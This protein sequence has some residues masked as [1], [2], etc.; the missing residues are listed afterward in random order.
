MCENNLIEI[1]ILYQKENIV[2]FVGF[3]ENETSLTIPF[4][5]YDTKS[6]KP[7]Y[8]ILQAYILE[9]AKSK[10]KFLNKSSGADNFK[11]SRRMQ[12]C[13]EY[14]FI[15]AKHL[16]PFKQ[17][18]FKLLSFISIKFYGKILKNLNFK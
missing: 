17:I 6:K 13:F 2:G 3:L 14:T 16:S 12:P 15:Y 18:C 11:T 8:R 10:N 4:I 7:L 1:Y 5:G 9:S